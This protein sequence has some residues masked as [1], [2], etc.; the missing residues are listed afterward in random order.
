MPQAML[1]LFPAGVTQISNALAFSRENGR[2]TYFSYQ[3]PIFI[4]QED[5]LA[6]FRMITSQFCVNGNAKQ[7]EIIRAFGV[8]PISVK[9]SV[10]KYREGGPAAFYA[11]PNR[12]GPAKLTPD[13][14]ARAQELLDRGEN[15]GDVAEKIGVKPNTLD[16]AIRAGKLHRLKKN[17]R[18]F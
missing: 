3:V 2:I 16:K 11:T 6:T 4:H 18:G 1:P 5:D 7:V 17:T 9:R 15:P 14:L 12:R 8:T 10:S 13:V